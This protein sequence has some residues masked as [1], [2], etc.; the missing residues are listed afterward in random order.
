MGTKCYSR[1][2][3]CILQ[4]E[5][6]WQAEELVKAAEQYINSGPLVTL[7]WKVNQTGLLMW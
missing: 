4:T 1:W 3:I 5:H 7:R 2:R 6:H